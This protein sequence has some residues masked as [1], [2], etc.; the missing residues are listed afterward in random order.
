MIVEVLTRDFKFLG[1]A[2][3]G[4]EEMSVFGLHF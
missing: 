2:A 4:D 3:V 1:L